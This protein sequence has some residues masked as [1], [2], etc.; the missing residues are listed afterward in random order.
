MKTLI[1]IYNDIYSSDIEKIRHV[2]LRIPKKAII[3]FKDNND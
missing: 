2:D 3:N 1:I